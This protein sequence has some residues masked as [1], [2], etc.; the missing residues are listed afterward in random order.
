MVHFGC[1][2]PILFY[3]FAIMILVATMSIFTVKI[4]IQIS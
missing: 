4:A 1:Q 2:S 3:Y